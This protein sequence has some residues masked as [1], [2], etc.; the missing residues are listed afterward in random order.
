MEKEMGYQ[1]TIS[2]NWIIKK[3][4]NKNREF[5]ICTALITPP[6]KLRQVDQSIYIQSNITN[7]LWKA[8]EEILTGE[9]FTNAF[10][11]KQRPNRKYSVCVAIYV[12]FFHKICFHTIKFNNK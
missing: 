10:G 2:I 4:E 9:T 3:K 12:T 7:L 5:N 6:T 1:T 11:V 8:S